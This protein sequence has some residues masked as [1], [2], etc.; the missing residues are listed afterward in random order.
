MSLVSVSFHQSCPSFDGMRF[1][2]NTSRQVLLSNEYFSLRTHPFLLALRLRAKRPQRRRAR[3]NGCF[4][5][6]TI[7]LLNLLPL[8][9]STN[10]YPMSVLSFV[11][12][13]WTFSFLWD[14]SHIVLKWPPRPELWL[15]HLVVGFRSWWCNIRPLLRCPCTIDWQTLTTKDRKRICRST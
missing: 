10:A 1:I 9:S 12:T 5:R 11:N 8:A 15:Y 2:D 7:F 3:R 4:P 6:L 13:V 14:Y